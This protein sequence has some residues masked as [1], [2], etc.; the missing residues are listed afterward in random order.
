MRPKTL[1]WLSVALLLA[2]FLSIAFLDRPLAL[3]I[4]EQL[5]S[6]TQISGGVTRAL[7]W[8]FAFEV[9]K[10]LYPFVFLLVAVILNLWRRRL[11]LAAR[12]W[13]FLGSTLLLS[14]LVSGTLKNVF[15][16]IRPYE[17]F[18]TRESGDFF[19]NGGS[20]F[21]SG[22]AAFYFG[23]F[24]PLALLFPK[25]RWPLLCFATL[26]ATARVFD[27]DHYLSD[28]IGS[29]L[30]AVLLVFLFAK[31]LRLSSAEERTGRMSAISL[32]DPFREN[33]AQ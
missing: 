15:A 6:V 18:K 26:A 12:M 8:I 7:E 25:L 31:L 11:T 29:A 20:S 13:Y 22:H 23:L 16:R 32:Q 33:P 28:I 5:Q 4:N 2:M 3:L 14:R 24:F 1:I 30:V 10:Y 21:P 19:V 9:S 17:F 27:L